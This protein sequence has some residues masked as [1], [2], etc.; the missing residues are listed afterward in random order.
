MNIFEELKKLEIPKEDFVVL[1]SGILSAL[2]IREV[3]D[4]DLLVKPELFQ[5]LIN[6]GWVYEEKEIWSQGRIS[7]EII[8]KDTVQAFKDFWF[9]SNIFPVEEGFNRSVVI[10]GFNFISLQT[11]LEYKKTSTREKDVQDVVLIEGYL[12]KSN[13]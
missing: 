13:L 1:G 4:I 2:G 5:K 12:K 10:E 7:R 9:D 3:G 11:L 8:S 6:Q